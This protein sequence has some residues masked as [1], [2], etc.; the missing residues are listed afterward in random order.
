MRDALERSSR[1][2]ESGDGGAF[3]RL[4]GDSARAREEEQN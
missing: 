2:V 4:E 3:M 1:S